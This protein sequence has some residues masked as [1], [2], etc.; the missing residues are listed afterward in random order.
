MQ[1]K[2]NKKILFILESF[3]PNIG[4][5]EFLFKQLVDKLIELKWDITVL[6]ARSYENLETNKLEGCKVVRIPVRSRYLFTFLAFCYS[7]FLIPGKDIV[8]TST[9]NA[10][11]SAFFISKLFNKKVI[12]T[13]HE[14][15]GKLWFEYPFISKFK[16]KL[17]FNFENLIAK[18]KFDKFVAV[19]NYTKDCLINCGVGSNRIEVIYNGIDYSEFESVVKN[20][21]NKKFTFLYSGRAGISKG[22]DVLI[23]AVKYL[24][25]LDFKL[26][27]H[28]ADSRQFGV[29]NQ[30]E[31]QVKDYK[32]SDKIIFQKNKLSQKDVF[33]LM[34]NADCIIVP[35]YSEGFCFI[36]AE[37][38]AM[39][40][41]I[42][43]SGRGALKEVVSGK[44]LVFENMSARSLAE[45][46][47]LAMEGKFNS[48]T[49]R[50][51]EI[52]ESVRHYIDVYEKL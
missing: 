13:F 43:H 34:K 42:I 6:T 32:L 27:I 17:F 35:S 29:L 18:L 11:L 39:G 7:I 51:F 2:K 28:S 21:D 16:Q 30:I 48:K 49:L 40:V 9:Y 20:L 41:P 37:A 4:G 46:M 25:E 10:A 1:K 33:Q 23:E 50:K 47:R 24:K 36:A 52:D 45:K 8:H 44:Y 5:V 15:W 12:V 22:L 3:Y 14:Y 31:K 38:C 19:S 26:I